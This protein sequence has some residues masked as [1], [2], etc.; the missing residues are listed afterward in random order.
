MIK[1]VENLLLF[2]LCSFLLFIYIKDRNEYQGWRSD[3]YE[4]YQHQKNIDSPIIIK[5]DISIKFTFFIN[6]KKNISD[7][8][9]YEN[10]FQTADYNSGIRVE[11]AKRKNGN[12]WG[13]IYTNTLGKMVGVS[14]GDA[15]SV[16]VWHTMEIKYNQRRDRLKIYVDDI[17]V[18]DISNCDIKLDFS[19]PIIGNGFETRYFNGLVKNFSIQTSGVTKKQIIMKYIIL[20][21]IAGIIIFKLIRV[22]CF[23]SI[24]RFSRHIF[25]AIK[26]KK[27]KE[28]LVY[29]AII[30]FSLLILIKFFNQ[31]SVSDYTVENGVVKVGHALNTKRDFSISFKFYIAPLKK[32]VNG[33]KYENLF[34]TANYNSG[35]RLELARKTK[36]ATLWG[37]VYTNKSGQLKVIELGTVPKYSFW[38][39]MV[40]KY[41]RKFNRI[42]VFVDG[43]DIRSYKN[44]NFTPNFSNITVGAGFDESRD[45]T[46]KIKDFRITRDITPQIL[47]II[48]ALI[49]IIILFQLVAESLRQSLLNTDKHIINKKIKSRII[50][51][52]ILIS[53]I[54]VF[55]YISECYLVGENN[56]I[57]AIIIVYTIIVFFFLLAFIHNLRINKYLK[58]PL[59]LFSSALFYSYVALYFTS[60]LYSIQK[61][62][63]KVMRPY[64]LSL[65]EV[66]AV[67]QSYFSEGVEFI[68]T[69]LGYSSL[70]AIILVP[71]IITILLNIFA[72]NIIWSSVNWRNKF[73]Y[74]LIVLGAFYIILPS[75]PTYPKVLYAGFVRYSQ[76][77]DEIKKFI[78]ERKKID[79]QI[80]L[81]NKNKGTHILIIGESANKQH[82]SAYGYF[83]DTTPWLDNT[84]KLDNLILFDNAYAPY[85]HT[86]PV[87][88]KMLTKANQ[89]NNMPQ[90]TSLSIVD[91][92]KKADFNTYWISEQPGTMLDTPLTVVLSQSD[93]IVYVEEGGAILRALNAVMSSIDEK[94]NN[95]IILHLM[96]SHADYRER[97]S[98]EDKIFNEIKVEEIGEYANDTNFVKKVLNPY[99]NTIRSTDGLLE[100]IFELTAN[101]YSWVDSF[102]YLSDHGEDVLGKKFHNSSSFN[103]DM[104]RVPL[105]MFFSNSYIKD[106][107]GRISKL[108]SKRNAIFTTDLLFNTL[109]DIYSMESPY[110]EKGY[111]IA[112]DNYII[113][114][115]NALTMQKSPDEDDTYYT[116]THKF[117]IKNDP[118]YIAKKNINY[119]NSLKADFAIGNNG[120]ILAKTYEISSLGF[121]GTEIN[122]A[123]EKYK[124]GHWPEYVFNIELADYLEKKPVR[125]FG[126]IWFDLKI[127]SG[128][129]I[130]FSLEKFEELDKKY[131]IKKRALIESTEVEGLDIFTKNGW[132]TLYYIHPTKFPNCKFDEECAQEIL[133]KFNASGAKHLSF[134]YKS[135]YTLV[136]KYLD[137]VLSD[138]VKYHIFGMTSDFDVRNLS[139]ISDIS[140]SDVIK[141]NRIATILF[142]S[143]SKYRY[144]V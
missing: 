123:L 26:N 103:Y 50:S 122:V 125:D 39:D 135:Y 21:L 128:G 65:D 136:K 62:S 29:I 126:K 61:Y 42:D 64:G 18:K 74:I 10:I 96:G 133:N 83:R 12:T 113:T 19:N 6:N 27:L 142:E 101:K 132:T 44:A 48:A 124:V 51:S 134:D 121:T 4:V 80:N 20:A 71:L 116:M 57:R 33:I 89:Y 66:A 87:I 86:V 94:Q 90:N 31:I 59:L 77:V 55:I 88:M 23:A 102:I 100:N 8:T 36:S 95:L 104:V 1:F 117:Y 137:S 91:I 25:E 143:P 114:E 75:I 127:K 14:L 53:L 49:S 16:S 84:K 99:D 72:R 108:R 118:I 129:N 93:K 70:F 107:I 37:V 58:L 24:A 35:I 78:A 67:Y 63:N 119:L 43:I 3:N 45:F 9:L 141:D 32:E 138:D 106:N 139:M 28:L 30:L 115:D 38:H 73:A 110:F 17:V 52:S 2:V 82:M 81:T 60:A 120:D 76:Q 15:P 85:C 22:Y 92:A 69:N 79:F 109:L 98:E 34:Q 144:K 105:F 97:L 130:G 140:D 11:I 13:L 47:Y 7:K 40:I 54:S 41:S 56:I 112:S 5:K 46:G 131:H 68:V 111:S